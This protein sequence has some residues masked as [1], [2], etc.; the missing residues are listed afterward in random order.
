MDLDVLL[1]REELWRIDDWLSSWGFHPTAKGRIVRDIEARPSKSPR[2]FCIPIR[3][4]EEIQLVLSPS[5]GLPHWRGLLHELG[6]A[7]HLSHVVPNRPFEDR[8]LGDLSVTEGWAVLFDHLMQNRIWL[9]RVLRL[10]P[11]DADLVARTSAATSLL[12]T[13]RNTASLIAE[14]ALAREASA[15]PQVYDEL[16][17]RAIGVRPLMDGT[18]LDVDPE[19]YS[20]RYV[21]AWMFEA[22][23]H[24]ALRERFDEDWFLNPRAAVFLSQLFSEGQARDLHEISEES[25]DAPLAVAPLGRR[26]EEVLS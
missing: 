3:V 1:G 7:L 26:Y 23:A 19:L 5:G 22:M 15:A 9:H 21:R 17:R 2:A 11:H 16:L 6:H 8:R 12:I 18:A 13:R 4:P 10:S 14:R 25:F 20:S 24:D